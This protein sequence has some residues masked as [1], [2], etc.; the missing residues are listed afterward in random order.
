MA[1]SAGP[2][3]TPDIFR[4]SSALMRIAHKWP[5]TL[6]FLLTYAW[7]WTLW[8][9]MAGIVPEGDL[10]ARLEMLFEGL[11]ALAAF[12]P[13][14]GAL[15]TS[16]LAYRSL[17]ICPVW[18]GWRALIQGLGFGLSAFFVV[19]VLAP[20]LAMSRAPMLSW[21]W[22]SVAHWSTYGINFSFFFGGPV[23]EE[24]GWRGFAL[25]R[26][27]TR[28]GAVRATLILAP[29]WAAW[30]TPLFWMQGW[31]SAT[32]WEY[33]LIVLGICFL[34]TAAANLA[35]FNVVVA[36]ALH[37]FFNTSSR[38]GNALTQNFPRR[39]HQMVIY[40]FAV[41]ICGVAIGIAALAK[42]KIE[43]SELVMKQ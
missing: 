18:T 41:F 10:P 2:I 22:S 20:N 39:P 25:P 9:L 35:K 27:Q 1:D 30:H 4:P 23:N 6:F 11:F 8:L 28:W 42:V 15:V 3:V 29:L 5:L 43:N 13:T 16:W 31:T 37:A 38:M 33:V 40:T 36:M 21:N 17:K 14:V 34:F 24:P 12:G 26:L 7:T 19:T 32:P